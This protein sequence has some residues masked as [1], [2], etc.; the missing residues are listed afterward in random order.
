M[1]CL[2]LKF[3]SSVSF[4]FVVHCRHS[5]AY[6]SRLS[7]KYSWSG[8]ILPSSDYMSQGVPAL[9]NL[10]IILLK[11]SDVKLLLVRN[12]CMLTLQKLNRFNFK[13]MTLLRVFLPSWVY[14]CIPKMVLIYLIHYKRCSDTNLSHP[15]TRTAESFG[16]GGHHIQY[17]NS[18]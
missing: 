7:D 1:L 16:G 14:S 5:L 11:W 2:I 18:S 4:K 13:S 3:I 6:V 15:Q 9:H 8:Y 17:H 10:F 12:E